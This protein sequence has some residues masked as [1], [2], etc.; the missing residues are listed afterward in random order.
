MS[1]NNPATWRSSSDIGGN[2]GSTDETNF[3]RWSMENNVNDTFSD[4]DH[5]QQNIIGIQFI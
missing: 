1:D 5:D 3:Q 2:P 4:S